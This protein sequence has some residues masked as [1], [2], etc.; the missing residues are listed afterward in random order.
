MKRFGLPDV[1]LALSLV[2]T[3]LFFT[4]YQ[5]EAAILFAFVVGWSASGAIQ[6]MME[7]RRLRQFR[8]QIEDVQ[9]AMD[10]DFMENVHS[11][12]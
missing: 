7:V 9:R 12:R 10:Y 2:A 6:T 8:R 5:R 4:G 11:K 1:G 3:A